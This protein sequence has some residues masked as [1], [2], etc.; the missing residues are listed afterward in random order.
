MLGNSFWVPGPEV[1]GLGVPNPSNPGPWSWSYI[2]GAEY[3]ALDLHSRICYQKLEKLD[4]KNSPRQ[5][6]HTC[7]FGAEL[8]MCVL[9]IAVLRKK[10]RKVY[11]EKSLYLPRNFNT[12]Y[13]T[14]L[15]DP[16]LRW[17]FSL[18]ARFLLVACYNFF[19]MHVYI[20]VYIYIYIYIYKYMKK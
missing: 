1:S 16:P 9:K 4:L 20:Y 7:C 8:R 6:T 3:L 13:I 17:N 10:L 15:T 19:V 5:Y 14:K 2:L 12:G 18:G 11:L